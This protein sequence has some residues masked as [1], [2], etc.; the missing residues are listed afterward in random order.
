MRCGVVTRAQ[1]R[2]EID[3]QGASS[4]PCRALVPATADLLL[5]S[6]PTPNS[7]LENSSSSI[8]MKNTVFK[9]DMLLGN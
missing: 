5:Y 2:H 3:G 1:C 7:L 4:L 9:P 8:S 6:C